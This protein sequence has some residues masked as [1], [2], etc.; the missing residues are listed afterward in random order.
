[1]RVRISGI[2]NVL[3]IFYPVLYVF[4]AFFSNDIARKLALIMLV[5]IIVEILIKKKRKQ[6]VLALV[7]FS[8]VLVNIV[9]FGLNYVVHQDFYSYIL[10]LLV[11]LIFANPKKIQALN[12]IISKKNLLV[13]C[14]SFL[15][16]VFFSILFRNGLQFSSEWG[17]SKPFLYGPYELPHSLAYQL[18]IMYAYASI[19]YHRYNDKTFLILMVVFFVL[20]AWTGVRSAFLTLVIMIALEFCKMR[21]TSTKM[22]IV[23]WGS[24]LLGYLFL[25]TN[26]PY[27]NPIVKKTIV[28]LSKSSGISNGRTDFNHYLL[29]IFTTRLS[30]GEYVFGTGMEKLR[31][32]M[33]LRYGT[34]LHAHNDILNTLIGMGV[35]GL[36][37]YS[38]LFIDFCKGNKKW[39]YALVP[40]F[41]LAFT[42]GLYL[43]TSFTP[44]LPILLIYFD[45]LI[46]KRVKK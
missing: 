8:F 41:V 26:I 29:S 25:F 22:Q 9:K 34:A 44:A 31:E 10:F 3:T 19:G 1:M 30:I 2:V 37:L 24:I 18:I 15:I 16:I 27:N 32:F 38:K 7:V 42:N 6:V 17:S 46:S 43:Y 5:L 13:L 11:C 4:F 36:A 35:F 33:F 39:G 23:I 40:I 45:G 12:S 28:A 14:Y 20:A 21:N